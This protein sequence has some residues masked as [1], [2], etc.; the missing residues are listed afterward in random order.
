M[1]RSKAVTCQAAEHSYAAKP[2]RKHALRL[3]FDKNI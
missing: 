2:D 3:D 1:Y